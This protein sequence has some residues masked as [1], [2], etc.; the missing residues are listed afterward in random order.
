MTLFRP[1]VVS[2]PSA[3]NVDVTGAYGGVWENRYAEMRQRGGF[4]FVVHKEA[5]LYLWSRTG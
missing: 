2:G 5:A 4:V 1:C 3:S